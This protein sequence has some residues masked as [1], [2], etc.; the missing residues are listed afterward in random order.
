MLKLNANEV[1][2]DQD[3][4]IVIVSYIFRKLPLKGENTEFLNLAHHFLCIFFFCSY[5]CF[6]NMCGEIN[7]MKVCLSFCDLVSY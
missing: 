4:F 2:P 7:E 5:L 1:F 3:N 6:C